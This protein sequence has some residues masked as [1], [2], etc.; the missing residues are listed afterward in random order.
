MSP[1]L[2][3]LILEEHGFR[4]SGFNRGM[5]CD[6]AIHEKGKV[7]CEVYIP[8]AVL[9]KDFVAECVYITSLNVERA[10]D[11]SEVDAVLEVCP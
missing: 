1:R 7:R 4:Y 2:A 9:D 8:I 10:L 3:S 6:I 5:W 11:D